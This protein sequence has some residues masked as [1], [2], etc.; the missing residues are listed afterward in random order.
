MTDLYGLILEFLTSRFKSRAR[1]GAGILVVW[2]T[3]QGALPAAT[4]SVPIVCRRL[5]RQVFCILLPR[6]AIDEARQV[7]KNAK[8]ESTGKSVKA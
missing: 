5:I 2:A 3:D 7:F 6:V 4:K 8:S 1:L